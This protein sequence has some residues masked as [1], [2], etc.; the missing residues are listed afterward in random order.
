MGVSKLDNV[1][2]DGTMLHA[3]A[4][5]H[6]ARSWEQVCKNEAERKAAVAHSGCSGWPRRGRPVSDSPDGTAGCS[7]RVGVACRAAAGH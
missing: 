1:S 7:G 2:F 5:K 4:S 3:N 6:T